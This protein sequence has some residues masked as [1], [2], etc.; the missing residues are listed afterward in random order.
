M[1]G[2]KI[3]VLIPFFGTWP[4]WFS[5]F[6]LSCKYNPD[7]DW[8]FFSNCGDLPIT[9]KNLKLINMTLDDFNV[10]ASR[11][12]NII[13]KLKHP[14]KL[15]DLKP[16]YGIIFEDY[17][18]D[19]D[20]WGYGDIDLIYGNIKKFIKPEVLKNYDIISSHK[21]FLAGHFCLLKNSPLV[22]D[23]FM[24]GGH[25][26]TI[27][28]KK[29]YSGFD[30][31]QRKLK[32][33]VHPK[34]IMRSKKLST[35]INIIYYRIYSLYKSIISIFPYLKELPIS[36]NKSNE[37]RLNDFTSIVKCVESKRKIKILFNTFLLDD[38][39][40]L[41]KRR[42]HWKIDWHQGSLRDTLDNKEYLYFHF[43]ISKNLRGF[44]IGGFEPHQTNFFIT[45]NGIRHE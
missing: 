34:F 45:K 19:Y 23:L 11:K 20:F 16:A 7:I 35:Q 28:R 41:K 30:E 8:F 15:C 22:K 33:V 43:M 4:E 26:L 38:L 17:I 39:M 31:K 32:V 1:K 14:F 44:K 10:L 24:Y 27:C 21:D 6:L 29:N 40:I 2:I 37:K 12:T 36:T 9:S 5:F 13:I 42:K 25:F 18:E 3:C